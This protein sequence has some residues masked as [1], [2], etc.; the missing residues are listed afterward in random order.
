MSQAW[1]CTPVIPALKRPRQ[2]ANKTSRPIRAIFKEN[3]IFKKKSNTRSIEMAHQVMV[4][5]TKADNQAQ[6]PGPTWWKTTYPVSCPLT[7]TVPWRLHSFAC[8]CTQSKKRGHIQRQQR[9]FSVCLADSITWK[10]YHCQVALKHW[11]PKDRTARQ[12]SSTVPSHPVVQGGGNIA[13][14]RHSVCGGIK[15]RSLC[16]VSLK[17][18]VL[19]SPERKERKA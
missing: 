9:N 6:C 10:Q 14:L 1:W 17:S 19:S 2:K 8:P 16:W 7:S 15:W 11:I 12:K 5:A 4:L 3:N 18:R 13:I